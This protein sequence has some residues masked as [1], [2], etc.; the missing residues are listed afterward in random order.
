[1]DVDDHALAVDI[2]DLQPRGFGSPETGSVQKQQDH[3]VANVGRG[4]DQLLD[5][6]RAKHHGKLLRH[7][8]Q[9]RVV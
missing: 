4:R 3:S 9:L 2:G 8:G 1:M 5:F 6:F 7:S